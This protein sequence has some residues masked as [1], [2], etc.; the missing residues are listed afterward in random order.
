MATI[1]EIQ[2]RIKSIR[3]TQK[4]TNAMYLIASMK[5]RKAKGEL[6]RTRPYFDMVSTEIKRVFRTA[7]NVKSHYF[8][9]PEGEKELNGTYAYLVITADKGLAGAYNMNVLKKAEEALN[10]HPDTKLYVVGEYGRQYFK[11]RGIP[12]ERNFL[13]TAQNPS[14]TRAREICAA[15][16]N[17]YDA[18][19]IEKIYI[20]YTDLK[21]GID[22]EAK[23]VRVLPF[24][25]ASFHTSTLEKKVN[26]PFEFFPSV[27]EVLD[28][29]IP[30]YVSGYIYS[31]LVDS[32]CS[33][34][35][36]RM[37]AM[38]AAND[39]AR[40]MIEEL[41]GQF[42]RIR[43]SEITQEITEITAGSRAIRQGQ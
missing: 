21:N 43:Q 25:R 14:M 3:D 11:R 26:T 19:E 23:S 29:L 4:I 13:Y 36:A 24:H 27:E 16:L 1:H 42:N 12:V 17:A 2:S 22:M 40:S 31:A 15:L 37:N 10:N 5:M 32:F 20:L 30:S 33:E 41:Q 8:Y 18:G 35:S 38:S 7:E 28:A 9:P 39:N 6:D 34:Q